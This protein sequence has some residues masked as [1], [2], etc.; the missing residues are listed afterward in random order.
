VTE[1]VIDCF[2]IVEVNEN[3]RYPGIVALRLENRLGQAVLEKAAVGQA[4]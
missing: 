1:A 2:E 4:C 3:N